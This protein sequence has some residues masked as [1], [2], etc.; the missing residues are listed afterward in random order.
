[1]QYTQEKVALSKV[2]DGFSGKNLLDISTTIAD[3]LDARETNIYTRAIF[4]VGN[5]ETLNRDDLKV[6]D[7]IDALTYEMHGM[8]LKDSMVT[9]ARIKACKKYG[10]QFTDRDGLEMH[11]KMITGMYA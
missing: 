6:L 8:C 1:M 11:M 10:M 5:K 3:L 2:V 4:K 7:K 9:K